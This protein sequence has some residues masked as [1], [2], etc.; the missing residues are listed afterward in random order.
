ML[1]LIVDLH[2]RPV[3]LIG[4]GKIGAGK[5]RQ[6]IAAGAELTVISTAILGDL[7]D[8]ISQ[9]HLRPYQS[10]DLAGAFLVVA[11][12]GDSTTNDSIVAEAA[13]RNQLLNVVDDPARSNFYFTA[14]HRDGEVS[15][16]VSTE[17]A[18]PALAQW[19]RD[20]IRRLLPPGLGDVA[21][22]LRR[23]R[24]TLHHSGQSTEGR[25]WR[26]RVR[27]LI[28]DRLDPAKLSSSPDE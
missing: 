22:Q 24:E 1:P 16:S 20:E 15:V 2:N 3:V 27:E 26:A 13:E 25:D 18:S 12:T 14:L 19:V 21:H 23:E 11:A 9:L 8:G 5:A 6:L 10:G 4:A 28:S 17:G 7:P